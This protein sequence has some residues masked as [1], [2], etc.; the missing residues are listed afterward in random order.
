MGASPHL[1]RP[2]CTMPRGS[3]HTLTLPCPATHGILPCLSGHRPPGLQNSFDGA[4]PNPPL[5]RS[6]S[7]AQGSQ[8]W[9]GETDTGPAWLSAMPAAQSSSRPVLAASGTPHLE[10][11]SQPDPLCSF[12]PKD[13]E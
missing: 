7:G 11:C 9:A 6:Q 12:T 2:L 4:H 5:L 1:P 3:L 8:G 13:K 10:G